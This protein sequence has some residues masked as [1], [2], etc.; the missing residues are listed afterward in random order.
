MSTIPNRQAERGGALLTMLWLAAALTVIAFTV[1]HTVRGETERATTAGEGVR[2]YFLATGGVERALLWTLWSG[3][4]NDD[5]TARYWESGIPRLTFDFP[6]GQAI[7][8]LVPESSK[9]NINEAP[10]DELFRALLYFGVEAPRAAVV[11]GGIVDWRSPLQAATSFDAFDLAKPSS[12]LPAHA[13]FQEIEELMLVNGVTPELFYGRAERTE[14]GQMIFHRGLRESVTVLGHAGG[15]DVNTA[16]PGVMAAAGIPP[17]LID[18]LIQRRRV[19]PFTR[20]ELPELVARHPSMAR[21]TL[22][23]AKLYTIRSTGRFKLLGGQLSETRRT[24]EAL[25]KLID[26]GVDGRPW[27]ILRWYDNSPRIQ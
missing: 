11:A 21:L 17:D 24:V 20:P 9:L 19:R 13:S 4:R 1:A 15:I 7:V 3:F 18:G 26:P 23:G 25:V 12:F 27:S 8:E 14:N 5:N 16:E 6:T 2:A 10:K 22:G